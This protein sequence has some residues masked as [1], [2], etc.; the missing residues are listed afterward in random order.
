M[1]IKDVVMNAQLNEFS[2]MNK[3]I[4]LRCKSYVISLLTSF[5]WL[6]MVLEDSKLLKRT[7]KVLLASLLLVSCHSLLYSQAVTT[8]IIY[9]LEQAMVFP[10]IC[11]CTC[12]FLCLE[13]PS[14]LFPHG[15][16]LFIFLISS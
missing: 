7:W 8:L 15:W 6:F 1:I 11:L 16:L 13:C 14:P 2:I 5:W 3:M 9:V 4:L 10:S 12:H